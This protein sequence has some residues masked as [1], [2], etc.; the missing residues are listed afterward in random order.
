MIM[1]YEEGAWKTWFV[2]QLCSF[3]KFL[4]PF[5]GVLNRLWIGS[6]TNYDASRHMSNVERLESRLSIEIGTLVPEL[7]SNL[8][9]IEIQDLEMEIVRFLLLIQ[10]T[11]GV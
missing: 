4:L 2:R 3:V 5:K 1:I 10:T 11:F 7:C 8:L 9:A 6:V